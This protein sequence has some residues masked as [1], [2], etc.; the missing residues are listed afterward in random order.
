MDDVPAA[1]VGR[2]PR[3]RRRG[4]CAS[5]STPSAC[6]A[7]CKADVKEGGAGRFWLVTVGH[8]IEQEGAPRIEEEQDLVF[9][10]RGRARAH[11]AR[12][13]TLHPTTSGSRNASPTRS[14]CS[15]SP[16]SPPTR[17]ASTTTTRTRPRS[18]ATPTSSCTGRSPRSCSP[19]SHA[20]G[21]ARTR[22][23]SRT[24]PAPRTSPT[25]ASGLRDHRPTTAASLRAV[26]ADGETAMTLEVR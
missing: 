8:T 6:R 9:R 11:R 1:H 18:R 20:P 26:R 4:R 24:A 23:R 19:S 5:A 7:S 25:A 3:A 2:R 12:T 10:D 14:C 16:R 15:A 21:A 17:T 22:T 13:P